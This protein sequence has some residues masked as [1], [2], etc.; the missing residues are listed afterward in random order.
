MFWLTQ[1]LSLEEVSLLGLHYV[2]LTSGSGT[3]ASVIIGAGT[4]PSVPTQRAARV[5]G[6]GR[7]ATTQPGGLAALETRNS[8]RATPQRCFS[9]FAN[10]ETVSCCQIEPE[11]D[12]HASLEGT[13]AP[14]ER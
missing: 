8:P 14:A 11:A 5:G 10:L 3:R 9:G 13:E 6:G 4:P 7:I 2:C 12:W 1:H